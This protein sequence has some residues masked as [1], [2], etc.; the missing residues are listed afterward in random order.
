MR[1]RLFG[2]EMDLPAFNIQ[3]GRDH[4]LASYNNI[5]YYVA[6]SLY[7]SYTI[8][9]LVYLLPHLQV[10]LFFKSSQL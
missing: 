8:N 5:R 10:N 2:E 3:R 6:L 4:G 1:N 9:N 7:L